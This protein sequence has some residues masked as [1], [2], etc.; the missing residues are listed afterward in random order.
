MCVKEVVGE[1]R[2]RKMEICV[3]TYYTYWKLLERKFC[4]IERW[5]H[6]DAISIG[7]VRLINGDVVI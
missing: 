5:R 1:D 2:D 4:V 3:T 7:C 6:C